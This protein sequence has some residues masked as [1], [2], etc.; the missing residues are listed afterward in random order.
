[1][2]DRRK[3]D[4]Q[5]ESCCVAY[6]GLELKIILPQPSKCWHCQQVLSCPLEAVRDVSKS[7][8]DL[9]ESPPPPLLSNLLFLKNSGLNK[10]VAGFNQLIN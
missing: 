7:V 10:L 1:M 8:P 2:K 4:R 5:I 9:Q 6:D 3:K